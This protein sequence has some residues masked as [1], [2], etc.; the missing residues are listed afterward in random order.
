MVKIKNIAQLKKD[1]NYYLKNYPKANS[2]GRI[3]IQQ[4]LRRIKKQIQWL[5]KKKYTNKK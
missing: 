2:S 3:Q 1:Y 4:H 5:E